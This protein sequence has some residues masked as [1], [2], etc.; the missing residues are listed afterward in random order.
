MIAKGV[1]L[2]VIAPIYGETLSEVLKLADEQGIE[3]ISYDRLIMNS[4]HISYYATFDN[5][6]VGVLQGKYIEER[7]G[8]KEEKAPATSNCLPVP[9]R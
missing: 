1:D 8:L 2:L 9:G 5:Y 7:L 4:P 6:Q 3:V